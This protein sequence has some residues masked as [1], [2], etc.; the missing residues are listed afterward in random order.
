MK[1]MTCSELGGACNQKFQASSF[2]EMAE[3]SKQHGMDMYQ[4]K[5]SAH[6]Q[7]MQ[8]MQAMQEMQELM[9]DPAAMKEW[10][11]SRRKA[12]DDLPDS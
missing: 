5:D 8:A 3:L 7:A 9:K 4:Q 12:F 2:D 1:T 6:L 11:E 10:F